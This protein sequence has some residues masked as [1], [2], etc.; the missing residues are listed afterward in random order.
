MAKRLLDALLA[1]QRLQ[2]QLLELGRVQGGHCLPTCA[3]IERYLTVMFR[4]E[5]MN[6]GQVSYHKEN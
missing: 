6:D 3:M 1:L 4:L 5:P 2:R